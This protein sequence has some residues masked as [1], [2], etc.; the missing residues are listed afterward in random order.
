MRLSIYPGPKHPQFV[1]CKLL[2]MLKKRLIALL[3]SFFVFTLVTPLNVRSVASEC[4]QQ[5]NL[6]LPA[7]SW[8]KIAIPPKKLSDDYTSPGYAAYVPNLAAPVGNYFDPNEPVSFRWED[9]GFFFQT[10]WT[11]VFGEEIM[12]KLKS[13]GGDAAYNFRIVESPKF[14]SKNPEGQLV[15]GEI[16]RVGRFEDNTFSYPS[17]ESFWSAGLVN[18]T[19]VRFELDLFV[20]GCDKLALVSSPSTIDFVTLPQDIGVDEWLN[21][22]QDF[23]K[24]INRPL[25]FIMIDNYKKLILKDLELM[26]SGKQVSLSTETKMFQWRQEQFVGITKIVGVSPGNCMIDSMNP[27]Y[28]VDIYQ[29]PCRYIVV[30]RHHSKP[31]DGF[32]E[33]RSLGTFSIPELSTKEVTSTPSQVVTIVKDKKSIVCVKGKLS[34]KVTA[35]KPKCPKGY[36]KK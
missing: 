8:K 9:F 12:Q 1:E 23:Y 5:W 25:N 13:L 18:G 19:Q 22:L 3:V 30:V 32:G 29:R 27:K 36:K 4:P 21:R 11:P 20:R 15:G 31:S 7:P 10:F 33:H 6:K 26:K 34:K 14:T 2:P 16:L 35:V 17:N 28:K 24:E